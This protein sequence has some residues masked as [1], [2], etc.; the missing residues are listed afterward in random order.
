MDGLWS[1][2][3]GGNG[4]DQALSSIAALCKRR[5]QLHHL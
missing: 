5:T 2:Q 3:E 1:D 4:Q